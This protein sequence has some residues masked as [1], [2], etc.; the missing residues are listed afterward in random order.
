MNLNSMKIAKG[1]RHLPKRV[2]LG[3]G[4]GMGK[5]ST[6]GQKGQGARQGSKVPFGFE[7]GN[8]PLYRR[9][10]KHGFVSP[11]RLPYVIINLEDLEKFE[12]GAAVDDVILMEAGLVAN[13]N[14]PVKVLGNG[15]LTKK[16]NVTAQAFSASAKKAIE[17]AGGKAIVVSLKDS[18]VALN[19]AA[20]ANEAK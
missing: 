9:V 11:N 3:L 13:L 8:F 20:S 12:N 14:H 1:S 10:P 6:R 18:R 17:A 19:K 15:K 7:G 2:G 4:S 5:T 16:L